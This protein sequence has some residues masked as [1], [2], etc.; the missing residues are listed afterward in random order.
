MF[1][2]LFALFS[3]LLLHLADAAPAGATTLLAFAPTILQPAKGANWILGEDELVEWKTDNIPIE[4][5]NYHL[6]ILLGHPD[7]NSE[8]LNTTYPL[9]DNVPIMQGSVTVV[10]PLGTPVGDGYVIA[11]IGTSDDLSSPFSISAS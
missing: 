7:N 10:L 2:S 6:R 5:Q 3:V 4:A 11:L 9:A 8:N 1:T